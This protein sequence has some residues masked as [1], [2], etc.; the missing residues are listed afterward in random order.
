MLETESDSCSRHDAHSVP[1]ENGWYFQGVANV[2]GT[3]QYGKPPRGSGI[4][5][6]T[7]AQE[8]AENAQGS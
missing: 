6:Q 7:N 8:A 2:L 4:R 5:A 1:L 3:L